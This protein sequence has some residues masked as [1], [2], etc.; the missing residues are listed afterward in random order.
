M[1]RGKR[2]QLPVGNCL[3]KSA[4]EETIL[5]ITLLQSDAAFATDCGANADLVTG[6]LLTQH[7]KR[8]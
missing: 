5:Y 8:R 7:S 6:L 2:A 3:M 4:H 1:L